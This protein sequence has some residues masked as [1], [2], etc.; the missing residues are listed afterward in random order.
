[1]LKITLSCFLS[2]ISILSFSQTEDVFCK[3]VSGLQALIKNKHYKPKP[4]NDSLSKGVFYLFLERLDYNKDFFLKSDFENLKAD[5]YKLDDYILDHNCA[6]ISKY[7]TLLEDRIHIAESILENLK[8]TSIDYSGKVDLQFV[9]HSEFTY[10]K[11]EEAFKIGLQKRVGYKTLSKLIDENEDTEYLKSN[12]NTLETEAKLKIIKNELC[13]LNEILHKSGGIKK[14]T[15]ESFLNALVQYND[16]NSTFFNDSEKIEFENELSK[17]QLSFGII[18]SKN[19][20]GDIIIS[21][22]IPGSSAFK[23]GL[24]EEED[25]LKTLTSNNATLETLCVSNNDILAFTNAE[26]NRTIT[27][28]VKKKNGTLKEVTL[29]KSKIRVDDNA[30]RGYLL[31]DNS[32]IGYIKIP[33]FYTNNESPN[34]R[35]LTQ[36]IAK[37]L[38]KLQKEK[39]DGLILDLRYNGGGS[40]QEAIELSGMFIDRGPLSIIKNN[41]DE[42]LTIRDLKRGSFYTKPLIVLVNNYSASASEFFACAM[43]DYNRAII[44]GSKTYGKSS[45]QTI[46]PINENENLGYCKLTIDAFY[47]VTG[48]SHQSIGVVP[49]I[50]LPTMF[51]NFETAE[52][53]RDYALKNDSV[54]IMSKHKPLP[55][56]KLTSIKLKSEERINN[57]KAFQDIKTNNEKLYSLLFKKGEHYKLSLNAVRKNRNYYKAIMDTIFN[58]ENDTISLIKIHNTKSTIEILEYST[59]DTEQNERTLDELSKDIYIKEAQNILIDFLNSNN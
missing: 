56:L 8:E 13:L 36:D 53:Y 11:D 5:E 6:F 50:T 57:Q 39:I 26:A 55:E 30:I 10:Y 12:F 2:F 24:L 45:A 42:K 21:G 23:N 22:I 32:N 28:T 34:G 47:R 51:E 41:T 48:K 49:D 16:P 52:F 54:A 35:G 44:V 20:N 58:I 29:T 17:S 1:M 59:D 15:E 4:I 33:S 27:F 18:T 7:I 46:I 38:Y 37:E 3:Q 40:M 43:Q 31:G 19:N 9:P 25:I 14:F